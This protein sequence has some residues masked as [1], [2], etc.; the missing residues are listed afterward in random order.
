MDKVLQS[1]IRRSVAE[2]IKTGAL[3]D[4]YRTAIIL[5]RRFPGVAQKTLVAA[6]TE[7]VLTGRGNALWEP[8]GTD[9]S[10]S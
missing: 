3:V 9:D 5:Q 7:V 4:V 6:V 1:H 2:D 10:V 8:P